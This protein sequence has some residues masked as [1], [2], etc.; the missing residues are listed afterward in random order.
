MMVLSRSVLIRSN[1]P[2]L[3]NLANYL[4]RT[5]QFLNRGVAY[6]YDMI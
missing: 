4:T 3:L 2:M 6:N 5:Y 1:E